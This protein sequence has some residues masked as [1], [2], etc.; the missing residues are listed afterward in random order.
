MRE[1]YVKGL[2]GGRYIADNVRVYCQWDLNWDFATRVDDSSFEEVAI[3]WACLGG[4][5]EFISACQIDECPPF[6]V[7]TDVAGMRCAEG[8]W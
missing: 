8:T 3:L 4:Y 5:L 6:A 7:L 1:N 2:L